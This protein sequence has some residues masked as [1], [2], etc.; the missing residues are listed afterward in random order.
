MKSILFED[1]HIIAVCKESKRFVHPM[2]GERESK[3]C[4]L[5][6]VRDHLNK[7]VYPINRLDRP[8]S[9]VV[10]FA[11]APEV[12][13]R[14][15]EIWHMPSTQKKYKC[16]H[17][18]KLE[19][20]GVFNSALT[21]K[22]SF[23]SVKSSIKQDAITLYDPKHFFKDHFCTYT[24]VEIKTGRYHQIRRHFRKSVMP[25]IGDR[26]HGKGPV[27][28][29]FEEKFGLNQIFLH[30]CQL[31]FVHPFTTSDILIE[32]EIPENLLCVL[33]KLKEEIESRPSLM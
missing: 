6:D 1:E 12:V 11:K 3:N 9:G 20:A 5:F 4:V 16:L 22:G 7:H 32:S 26:T 24:E 30:S 31:R 15:Q 19:Q 27:N 17:R 13:T 21:K 25:I 14:F 8:V 10:L 28:R 2:P 18:G 23:S 29:Y 33:S